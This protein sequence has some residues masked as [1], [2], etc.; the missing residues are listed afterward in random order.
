MTNHLFYGDNLTVLRDSI[1]AESGQP[2]THG[3]R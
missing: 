2:M 3:G 1:A